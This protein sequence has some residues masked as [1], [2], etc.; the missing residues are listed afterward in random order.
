MAFHVIIT[1]P[2]IW[3]DYARQGMEEAARKARILTT[4]PA[5]PTILAFAPEPEAAALA[6]LC[7]GGRN[8]D[9][10]DLFVICDAG[11]GTVS[12]SSIIRILAVLES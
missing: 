6:T 3:K 4:R 7:E 12:T 8:F 10:G 11:S 5:G 9:A 1:V 2:A